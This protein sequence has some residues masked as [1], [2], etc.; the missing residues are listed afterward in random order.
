MTHFIW[1]FFPSRHVVYHVTMA[2]LRVSQDLWCVFFHHV[3]ESVKSVKVLRWSV[4]VMV[5]LRRYQTGMLLAVLIAG[6]KHWETAFSMCKALP[7]YVGQVSLRGNHRSLSLRISLMLSVGGSLTVATHGG[8]RTG[9]SPS[10]GK[11]AQVKDDLTQTTE[12]VCEACPSTCWC[13]CFTYWIVYLF[14]HSAVWLMSWKTEKLVHIFPLV[15]RLLRIHNLDFSRPRIVN[16]TLFLYVCMY[17]CII[18]MCLTATYF[19][20]RF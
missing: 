19:L 10:G 2:A 6:R 15:W 1:V 7:V 11:V 20:F 5:W 13:V 9:P 8:C 3:R 17:E 16:L 14:L 12:H 18:C 4:C